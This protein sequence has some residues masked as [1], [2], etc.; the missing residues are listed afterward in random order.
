MSVRIF[1]IALAAFAAVPAS[2]E[3][4]LLWGDTHVHTSY[5]TDSFLNKNFSIDPDAAYRFAKG[6]PVMHPSTG[7]EVQ[8]ETPLD[9]LV[10]ADHAESFGIIRRANEEGLPREGLGLVDSF[11]SWTIEQIFR[12]LS[13]RPDSIV[14]V[15]KFAS[16]ETKDPVEAAKSPASLSIPNDD[17]VFQET[18]VASTNASDAHNN[19]GE[20]TALIGWEWSS[21]PAGANLHR[22]VFTSSD[23]HVAQQFSPFSSSTSSYPED[24]WDWLSQTSA[25]TGAD[26]VAIPHNSNISRGFM[27]PA[28]KRLRDTPIDREWIE[29]R[30]RWETVVEA[31]QIKGDSETDPAVSPNDP[32]ADFES[33]PHYI[34]PDPIP[35][36]PRPADFVRS[37]L[38]T[39]LELEARFGMNPY[40]FG[41]IGS[42]D[43]HTG[44][45]T[46]EEPNFWGKFPTDSTPEDRAKNVN[47]IEKFGWVV[48]A[49]GLAA[50]WSEENSRESIL[51]AFK[52]R[53][54]YSTT[55]P[56]I[57]L[58]VYGGALDVT[59]GSSASAKFSAPDG[60]RSIDDFSARDEV[61]PQAESALEPLRSKKVPMGGE[62]RGLTSPP[63]FVISAAKDPMS[64]HLDRV[65]MIKGWMRGGK[66][67][68]KV[69]DVVWSGDRKRD[70]EGRVP[71][72]PDT[73]DPKTG[74]Y[75][76]AYGSTTLNATWEDPDFD[77]GETAFYYVRVLEIPTP[78]HST[79]DAVAAGIAVS[80]T[81]RPVSI[82]ERAYSSPIHYRP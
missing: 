53:E 79:L 70:S 62:L 81:G 41:L 13:G 40:R 44:L 72:V 54:V 18:W 80:E 73:V 30:A 78:R 24:L 64:A 10:V 16:P 20:F 5:S 45:A 17:R 39:G 43:S 7:T 58:R 46:A 35:F 11:K 27:F 59:D 36:D 9:F 31:T 67:H 65:Q 25:E 28:E 66:S 75:S 19:P 77:S 76:N 12:F 22:V 14:Q 61:A 68:E 74:T 15:L 55:G 3:K 2:A 29:R 23:A 32:F 56:R 8:I 37:G 82:Q 4:E 49:S 6:A 34:S 60:V 50:V 42:T 26:F 52:R 33:Y 48:S 1:A 51:Q 47:H 21:I 63:S 71:P 57:A 38:R 69:Y